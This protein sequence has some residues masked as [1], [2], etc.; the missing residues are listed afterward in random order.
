MEFFK[1]FTPISYWALIV[2]RHWLPKEEEQEHKN[3]MVMRTGMKG[4]ITRILNV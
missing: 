2:L 4:Q 1:Y 3:Y